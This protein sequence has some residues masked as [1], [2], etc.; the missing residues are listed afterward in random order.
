M[1]TRAAASY[2]V[3][4]SLDHQ[5]YKMD[6]WKAMGWQ[7]KRA[8]KGMGAQSQWVWF[9]ILELRSGGGGVGGYVDMA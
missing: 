3:P 5:I 7:E 6:F 4:K 2:T 9:W 1:E 8:E